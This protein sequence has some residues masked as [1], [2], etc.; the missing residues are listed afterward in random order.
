MRKKLFTLMGMV[1]LLG[2]LVPGAMAAFPEQSLT[3]QK[4]VSCHAVQDGKISRVEEIRASPDEWGVIIDRMARLHGMDMN[5]KERAILLEEILETQILSPEEQHQVW[6]LNLNNNPQT[7]E[8]PQGEWEERFYAACV[9]CHS[10]GKVYSYRMT[11]SAWGK[12][13]DLHYYVDPAIDGQMREMKWYDEAG[14]ILA[15]LGRSLGYGEAWKAPQATIAGS[16]IIL[17]NEPG[18]GNYRGHVS[19]KDDPSSPRSYAMTGTLIFDDGTSERFQGQ[20]VLYGGHALRTTTTHNNFKTQGA[21]SFNNGVIQGQH[22]FEA[23]NFRTSTSTWYPAN[24]P[25]Q[26]LKVTPS[27]LLAGETTTLTLEGVKLPNVKAADLKFNG[28][29]VRVLEAR[30]V[31]DTIVAEVVY[32]GSGIA[33]ASLQ[34]NN[35]NPVQ[36]TLA[37]QID[38]IKITPGLGRARV[39]GGLHYPA[40]GVQFEA[41]A[42]AS[43]DVLLGVVPATFTLSEKVTREGDDDL[44]WLG[45]IGANGRYIP[46]SDYGQILN[47]EYQ[48]EG[49]GLVTVD[50]AYERGGRTYTAEA[51]LAVVPP[52]YVPRIK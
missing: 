28:G 27:Y 16:W 36:V 11:E 12:I 44:V 20:G 5:A 19:I 40:E 18:K 46:T 7:V 15:D 3:Y 1:L 52:D 32:Q 39:Y 8:I 24:G 21:F 23:P 4:C 47:R 41:I 6:Y 2:T 9:R 37:D 45:G 33:T 48:T 42:Y 35:L 31:G 29:N 14:E 22:H 25:A 51:M 13:R 30:R 10:A 17:G 34:L 43:G 38:H 49:T 26:V 50:A